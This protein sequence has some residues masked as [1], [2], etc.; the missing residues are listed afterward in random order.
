MNVLCFMSTQIR[1]F[2]AELTEIL[3]PFYDICA[4]FLSYCQAGLPDMGGVGVWGA[5]PHQG[6]VPPIKAC[7]PSQNIL[8]PPPWI[9]LPHQKM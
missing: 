3:Q 1:S 6:A 2:G 5:I 9:I 7:P 4:R 8:V